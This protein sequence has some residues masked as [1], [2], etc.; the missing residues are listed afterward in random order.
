MLTFCLFVNIAFTWCYTVE[1]IKVPDREYIGV[2]YTTRYYAPMPWQDV[3]YSGSY[4]NDYRK[5]CGGDCL[6]TANGYKLKAWDEYKVFACPKDI[7]L[8]TRL[9]IEGIWEGRCLDRGGYI[10]NKRLDIWVGIWEDGIENLR[11]KRA[12]DTLRKVYIINR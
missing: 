11:S 4:D 9:F 5:N 12:N 1:P 3:Y 6:I 10:R 7:P 8:W 2:Y